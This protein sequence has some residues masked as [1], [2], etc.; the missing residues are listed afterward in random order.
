MSRSQ[1][2]RPGKFVESQVNIKV[3]SGITHGVTFFEL[4]FY[5]L[6]Q[7]GEHLSEDNLFIPHWIVGIPLNRSSS[8]E[9]RHNTSICSTFPAE[10]YYREPSKGD[11]DIRID[12][13]PSLASKGVFEVGHYGRVHPRQPVRPVHPHN[14]LGPLPRAGHAHR[15]QEVGLDVILVSLTFG[16]DLDSVTLGDNAYVALEVALDPAA[17]VVRVSEK[18]PLVVKLVICNITSRGE[19][20][21]EC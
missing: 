13:V 11:L 9:L 15:H 18:R 2:P 19:M 7:R 6:A 14:E 20:L 16:R 8:L 17:C 10:Y 12:Q 1:C 4:N 21:A 5:P 3:R